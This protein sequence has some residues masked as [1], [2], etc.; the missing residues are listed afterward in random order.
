MANDRSPSLMAEVGI[1][2]RKASEEF[3]MMRLNLLKDQDGK[4][5]AQII[6]TSA[7]I[8]V[9]RELDGI[10]VAQKAATSDTM[11]AQKSKGFA[12]PE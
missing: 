5:V 12:S 6:A 11:L 7:R 1:A 10:E 8:S 3:W 9:L 4:L 2:T